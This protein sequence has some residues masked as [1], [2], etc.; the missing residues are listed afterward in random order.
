MI[1]EL[2]RR[3]V[4]PIQKR[5]RK[6]SIGLVCLVLVVAFTGAISAGTV[7]THGPRATRWNA[8]NAQS[9]AP[10][11]VTQ[12]VVVSGDKPLAPG[13][14][15]CG[16]TN[17]FYHGQKAVFR[18][19]VI[20]PQTGKP[21]SASQLK[22][23]TVHISSGGGKTLQ[24]TYQKQGN[25][26]FWVAP[27][28][29]PNSFPSGSVHY[30]ISVTGQHSQTVQF[31]VP[32]SEMTVLNKLISNVQTQQPGQSSQPTGQSAASLPIVFWVVVVVVALVVIGLVWN[33][34]RQ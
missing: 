11:I 23:V 5:R 20:D 30:T 9:N 22:G 25:D 27:W 8:Q 34:E 6:V 1:H 10:L 33:A 3:L 26:T 16:L 24:A 4:E 31:N 14:S 7:A 17:Q 15:D 18:I 13:Q 32:E 19:K 2:H 29:I 28:V 12:D 21:M